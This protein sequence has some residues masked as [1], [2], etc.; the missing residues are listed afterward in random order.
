[1]DSVVRLLALVTA[2]MTA[3]ALR[4]AG[5]K[6]NLSKWIVDQPQSRDGNGNA[7]LCV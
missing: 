3:L 6:I 5:R 1:M 4:H 7:V 2:W